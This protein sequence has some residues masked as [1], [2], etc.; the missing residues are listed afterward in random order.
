MEPHFFSYTTKNESV[1]K[2]ESNANYTLDTILGVADVV[3]IEEDKVPPSIALCERTDVSVMHLW[4]QSGALC[5]VY[6]YL[7]VAKDRWR[8]IWSWE[9]NGT[10][11]LCLKIVNLVV[12][13]MH[14]VFSL[15]SK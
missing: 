14:S 13:I 6:R 12:I 11:K 9:S 3:V 10:I 1:N 5:R 7:T 15:F 2:Y 4:M 8:D